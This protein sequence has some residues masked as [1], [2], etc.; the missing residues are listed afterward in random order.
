MLQ[1]ININTPKSLYFT[2]YE[3][4]SNITNPYFTFQIKAKD[5]LNVYTFTTQDYSYAPYYWNVFT[6]S[7]SSTQSGLTAGIV[8]APYGEYNYT[9]YE[10]A[11]QYDL[12]VSNAINTIERGIW[13]IN[14]TYSTT[15]MFTQ[16]DENTITIF[17]SIDRI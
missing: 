13:V 6:F 15:T 16:S 11:N 12:N 8:Q 10:M 9:V 4:C 14:P 1:Y 5:S 2:L 7:V 3:K 17:K